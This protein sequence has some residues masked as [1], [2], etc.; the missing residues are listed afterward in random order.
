MPFPGEPIRRWNRSDP[1]IRQN[2]M[3]FLVTEIH[4]IPTNIFKIQ[5]NVLRVTRRRLSYT[6][7]VVSDLKVEFN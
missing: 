6:R 7:A 2:P 3:G 1:M 5:S 4:Q